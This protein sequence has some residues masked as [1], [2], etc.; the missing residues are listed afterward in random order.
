MLPNG[1]QQ[2][3]QR[4]NVRCSVLK[5]GV[6]AETEFL[7]E[8]CCFVEIIAQ[9]LRQVSIRS[10]RDE[11]PAK[12][13]VAPQYSCARIRLA[14]S[15]LETACIEFQTFAVFDQKAEDR[16]DTVGVFLIRITKIFVRAV[17]HDVVEMTERIE[18]C[19]IKAF[20]SRI[21]RLQKFRIAGVFGTAGKVFGIIR[22]L[23]V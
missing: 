17:A 7:Q 4:E 8:C 11:L 3:F 23:L 15:V 9:V 22:I 19:R 10:D 18:R 12:L 20:Q 21:L 16:V 1:M 13:P 6:I 2:L 5:Y 14:E